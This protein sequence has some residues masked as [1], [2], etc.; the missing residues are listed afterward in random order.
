[1]NPLHLAWIIPPSAAIGF[2]AAAPCAAG[3]DGR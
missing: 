1:M 3:R 2:L